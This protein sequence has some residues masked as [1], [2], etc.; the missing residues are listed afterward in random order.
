MLAEAWRIFA[1]VFV[2]VCVST[3]VNAA[4]CCTSATAF[5]TGRLLLWES[6]ATG[7]RSQLSHEIGSYNAQR[8]FQ[9]DAADNIDQHMRLDAYALVGTSENGAVFVVLPWLFPRRNDGDTIAIGS[10]ISDIQ[11]GY[12][13]QIIAIGEY[14]EIPS[15]ALTGSILIPTGNP[16]SAG[17]KGHEVTGR[18]ALA[19]SAGAS[20][21]KTWMPFFVQLN[22]GASL[23]FNQI[24]GQVKAPDPI[25]PSYQVALASGMEITSN[26]VASLM[27]S[28]TYEYPAQW[29]TEAGLSV[30]WRLNPHFTL[31][32]SASSDLFL[33]GL[34]SNWPA[35]VSY[36]FGIRYGHF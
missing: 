32:A 35:N 19:L 9:P 25:V 10:N 33:N 2:L 29:K 22:L 14:E 20:L 15:L 12:R 30:S 28:W 31:Q 8:V 23:L 21:E 1:V 13:H 18:N 7:L 24:R 34:G 5:G 17:T 4:A 11:V 3:R 6:F 36:G 16:R 26:L 27:G